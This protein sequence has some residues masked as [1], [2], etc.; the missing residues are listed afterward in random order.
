MELNPHI[1]RHH[2]ITLNVGGAQEDYDFHTKVLGLKSVKKTGLYDGNDPIYHLYYG[3][4]IGEESTLVTCFPMR[5]SGRMGRP[6]SGQIKT[7][8]LSVPVSSLAF[9]AKHLESH[10]FKPEF[11]ERFGEKLLHFAHPCGICYELV[12][13]ADDDRK[14][15]SNGVVPS[16]FGI[17]GTHGITVSVRELEN[18]SE[19]MHYGWNGT[20][21]H[22]D[23]LFTRYEVGNGGS[24]AIIDYQVESNL[25]QGSWAY[26]EGTVHHCAFEVADLDVQRNVKLHLEGLGY[27]D[28]SDRKDRGYFDSVYVRTP[29]G[30]LFEATVSKPAGF[31]VDEPYESLGSSIQVPPQLGARAQ[32]IVAYLEPLKF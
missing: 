29:S 31:T 14:P 19:F 25:P 12:G 27:T 4:D 26:G 6:G 5:Q 24:G 17:R 9:W 13:I 11:Q 22:T 1:L 2:H 28:V 10:G 8:A 3:N 15:Y 30:A 7:L 23:G 16:G 18:S 20:K 32:E 21:T